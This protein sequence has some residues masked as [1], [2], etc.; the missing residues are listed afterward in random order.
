M[1]NILI[2][3][4]MQNGFLRRKETIELSKKIKK[5][6]EMKIFDVVVGTRFL[7]AENSAYEKML[8]W[9]KMKAGD[10]ETKIPSDLRKHMNYIED[11]YIYSCVNVNFIQRLCQLN[12]GEIPKKVFIVGVDTDCCVLAIATALFEYNIRPVVLTKYCNSTGGLDFHKAGSMC[13]KR[14][15]GEKQLIDKEI[16]SKEDL[17][18]LI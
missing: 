17:L 13:M 1:K 15:V 10:E 14:L 9:S 4:D 16:T 18:K 11:K 12:D 3:V 5:L 6:L 8:D 7:N 2:V